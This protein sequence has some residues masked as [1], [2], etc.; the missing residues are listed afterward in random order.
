MDGENL[1]QAQEPTTS[2][3]KPWTAPTLTVAPVS[4]LTQASPTPAGMTDGDGYTS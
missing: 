4:E 3:L 1:P 2:E